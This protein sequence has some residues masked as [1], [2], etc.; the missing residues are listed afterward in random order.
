MHMDRPV[1]VFGSNLAGRHD[2]GAALEALRNR[3]AIYGRGFGPQGNSYAIPIKDENLRSLS[4]ERIAAWVECFLDFARIHPWLLFEVTPIACERA[5][6][7]PEHIAPLFRYVPHNV[8][9]PQ[10]FKGS[11]YASM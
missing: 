5:G 7:K 10:A 1:F 2:Q 3:G 9:L 11:G 6:Y 8:T 4:L